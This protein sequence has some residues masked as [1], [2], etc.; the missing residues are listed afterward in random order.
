MV[1]LKTMNRQADL[2][3]LKRDKE[4]TLDLDGKLKVSKD[5]LN[6]L[7]DDVLVKKSS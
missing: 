5:S 6:E 1:E 4:F 2:L 7:P 3:K